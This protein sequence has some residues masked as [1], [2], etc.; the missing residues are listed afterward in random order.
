M[1]RKR[2]P[3]EPSAVMR[4]AGLAPPEWDNLIAIGAPFVKIP[5]DPVLDDES[6]VLEEVLELWGLASSLTDARRLCKQGG[7]KVN[8][9]QVKDPKTSLGIAHLAIFCDTLVV[10]IAKGKKEAFW[11]IIEGATPENLA[12]LI[13][14]PEIY[15]S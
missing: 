12:A 9:T 6:L 14:E 5:L 1:L 2:K 15:R 13:G 11:Y 7:I 4:A 3:P 10:K 8:G